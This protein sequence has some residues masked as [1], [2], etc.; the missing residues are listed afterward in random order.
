MSTAEPTPRLIVARHRWKQ[1]CD[2]PDDAYT[3]RQSMDA[4]VELYRAER[5]AGQWS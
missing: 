4:D 5:E 3:A 1:I 2:A